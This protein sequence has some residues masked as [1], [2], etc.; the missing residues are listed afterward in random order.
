MSN[1]SKYL[2]VCLVISL[3]V[4]YGLPTQA[5]KLHSIIVVDVDDVGIGSGPDRDKMENFV[6]NVARHA[7]LT[8]VRPKVVNLKGNLVN[9]IIQS[10]RGT[11]SEVVKEA[12][13]ST[14]Y[15][16]ASDDVVIFYYSGHGLASKVH[17][18]KWPQL[19]VAGRNTKSNQFIE[20]TWIHKTLWEANP[21]LLF[22]IVDACNNELDS[23]LGGGK[24]K[25]RRLLPSAYKT[26]FTEYQ[27]YLL[28]SSSQRGE[29]SVG[30]DVLGGVFTRAFFEELNIQLGHSN[31]SWETIIKNLDGKPIGELSDDQHPQLDGNHLRRAGNVP[32]QIITPPSSDSFTQPQSSLTCL[33]GEKAYYTRAKDRKRCCF[34]DGGNGEE[35]C[36]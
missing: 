19:A 23:S 16:I 33:D 8:L 31:P 36:N 29:Y 32:I 2:F 14:S 28:A 3:F 1:F 12:I 4:S 10:R 15:Q 6:K 24:E 13:T 27:G 11:G 35:Y 17:G 26:L 22:V 5:A 18:E 21:K 34:I 20:M 30:N 7:Q 25:P 9:G